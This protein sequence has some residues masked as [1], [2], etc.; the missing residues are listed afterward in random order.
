MI[1]SETFQSKDK[2]LLLFNTFTP[3]KLKSGSKLPLILFLHGAGERG[4]DNHKPL[5]HV[6]PHL[7]SK[8]VQK[9][10][11]SIIVVP[12]CPEDQYW[13]P[14]KRFEWSIINN[15]EVTPPM[16]CVIE[17]L[18][19]LI[20]NNTHIDTDRI[21]IVGMSMGSFGTLD[22]LSRRPELF[23][24]AVPICGGADLSKVVNYKHVPLWIFHGDKDPVVSIEQSRAL[25]YQLKT[26]G[27]ETR[28]TE[29]PEAG[30]D[31]WNTAIMEPEVL[32]WLFDQNKKNNNHR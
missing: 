16:S 1:R 23:A 18:D 21:Y 19:H 32:P 27:V 20:K 10:Y 28:Y 25:I 30:H 5:I 31:I 4:S 24:A 9:K 13:A 11:K 3:K 22:L 8:E 15:G 6:V 12:Q 26:L 2:D 14:V 29:Y 17:L 7:V